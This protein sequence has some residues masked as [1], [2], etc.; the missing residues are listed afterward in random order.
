MDWD[1]HSIKR[2]TR[3]LILIPWVHTYIEHKYVCILTYVQYVDKISFVEMWNEIDFQMIQL[4][5]TKLVTNTL[6]SYIQQEKCKTVGFKGSSME[7][8]VTFVS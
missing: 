5:K 2:L 4:P 1:F 3:R 6:L 8:E 7:C